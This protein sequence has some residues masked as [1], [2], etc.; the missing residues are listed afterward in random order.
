MTPETFPY[1]YATNAFGLLL[2]WSRDIILTLGFNRKTLFAIKRALVC[3]D[4]P[5]LFSGARKCP[6]IRLSNV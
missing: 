6:G 3:L 1:G 5:S 2:T 4:V